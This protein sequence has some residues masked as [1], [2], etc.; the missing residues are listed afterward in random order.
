MALNYENDGFDVSARFG[1]AQD[2]GSSATREQLE[3]QREVQIRLRAKIY[4]AAKLIARD[5]ESSRE[6]ALA[7]TKLE[8]ALLWGGKAI[9][10]D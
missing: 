4:D 8:E 6:S 3:T 9:F 5:I 2:A 1:I 10:K 7:I